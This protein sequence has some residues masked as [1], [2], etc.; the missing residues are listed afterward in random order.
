MSS[1]GGRIPKEGRRAWGRGRAR[2][3]SCHG[4]C[5]RRGQGWQR[6]LSNEESSIFRILSRVTDPHCR[7]S[8]DVEKR[9]SKGCNQ[10]SSSICCVG[11]GESIHNIATCRTLVGKSSG[12]KQQIQI[13]DVCFQLPK[14][15]RT[16]R[17]FLWVKVEAPK[18]KKKKVAA[19]QPGWKNLIDSSTWVFWKCRHQ[20][21][22]WFKCSWCRKHDFFLMFR[23]SD[24]L[25]WMCFLLVLRSIWMALYRFKD[26]ERDYPIFK[27]ELERSIWIYTFITVITWT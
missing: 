8:V 2:G 25:Q 4:R 12:M 21:S 6:W 7:S 24:N 18:K 13:P 9:L 16:P 20:R 27:D 1:M 15:T 11:A 10:T 26:L 17:G 22:C 23:A 5:G 3:S 19:A 14:R